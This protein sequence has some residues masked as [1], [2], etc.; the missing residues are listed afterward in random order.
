MSTSTKNKIPL[1]ATIKDS[2]RFVFAN[3]NAVL[4]VFTALFALLFISKIPVFSA[5]VRNFQDYIA[6]QA[7]PFSHLTLFTGIL[8][9]VIVLINI[10]VFL[11]IYFSI[12]NFVF[13]KKE[14]NIKEI[15]SNTFS[16][17]I[18]KYIGFV[19]LTSV[20]FTVGTLILLIP[21]FILPASL[22]IPLLV[23]ILGAWII[24][25]SFFLIIPLNFS[26]INILLGKKIDFKNNYKKFAGFRLRSIGLVLLFLLSM[27]FIAFIPFAILMAIVVFIQTKLF[28]FGML[29]GCIVSALFLSAYWIACAY[30]YKVIYDTVL[31]TDYLEK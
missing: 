26:V 11:S 10:F 5:G 13:L 22:K 7:D 19:I 27:L 3:R 16:K 12:I 24:Y 8:L 23:V 28:I 9:F 2:Y 14:I 4:S 20:L 18:F 25:L 17:R 29:L 1:V 31:G 15:L 30:I 6:F 21:A